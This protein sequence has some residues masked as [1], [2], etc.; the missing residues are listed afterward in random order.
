MSRLFHLA[1]PLAALLLTACSMM[2]QTSIVNQPLTARPQPQSQIR[3]ANG[4]IFQA[5]SARGLFEEALPRMVGDTLTVVIEEKTQTQSAESS[6]GSRNA[7]GSVGVPGFD[8]PFF[9]NYIEDKVKQ[10]NLSL[11]GSLSAGGSGTA[12]ASSNFLSTLTTTVVEVLPNGNLI[13]S[14]EKQV[15]IN[16]ELEFIRLSGVVNPRDIKP[17]SRDKGLQQ[18]Y[19]IS[20]TRLADARIEQQNS[21]NNNLFAQPGWLTKF[22]MTISPF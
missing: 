10:T 20:S 2:P 19:Y 13:I 11:N 3:P 21:G 8:L 18:G 14:G 12:S 4:A 7:S 6:K 1:L 9:P 5:S 17:F 22:F 15:R 16:G